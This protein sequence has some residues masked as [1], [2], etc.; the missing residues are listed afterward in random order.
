MLCLVEPV[1]HLLTG[2]CLSRA[3]GFPARARYA[4]AA[5]VIAAELPDADFVY[6]LGGPLL[7]FQ[8]HRGW[9]HALWSLP[10][11]AAA[12][13]GILYGLHATR[14]K[15]KKRRSVEEP[16]P[17]RWP[18]L[19]FMALLALLSHLLLDWTNNYGVRPFAPFN[20]RWYSGDLVFIVEPLLLLVLS[21][22]LVVPFL[23][24]LVHR[25]M[26][27]RRPRY[28]GR[29]LSA[30]ALVLMAGLWFYRSLQQGDAATVVDAQEFRGGRILR[31]SLNPYPID[32]YRWH[33]VVETPQNFQSG[34]VDTRMNLFETDPQQIYAKPQVTL[35]TLAAKQSWLGEIYL[36]WSRFPLVVDTGTVGDTH[37][38]LSPTPAEAALRNVSFS[39]LRFRYDVLGMHSSEPPLSAEAWVDANRRV[40]EAY[41]GGVEQKGAH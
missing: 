28:Q 22:A 21:M 18:A 8:H 41:F 27:I 24:S 34:T 25:E 14:R 40:Q 23:F 36:D 37:P 5:C 17:V 29:A 1:T 16:A 9:T 12:V 2:A 30:V 39:D 7:Y 6:R 32:P 38:E 11:Q 13:V 20:P 10:L 26:G 4:T 35:A 3:L 33:V 15:W 19:F 31:R